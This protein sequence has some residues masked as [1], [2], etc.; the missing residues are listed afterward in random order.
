MFRRPV[1]LL[2]A[3]V[4]A[5]HVDAGAVAGQIPQSEYAARRARV[6]TVME[7]RGVLLALGAR[8]PEFDYVS[9]YQG[10]PFNYLTGF[11]EPGAALVMVKRG[12]AATATLFVLPRDPAAEV[13]TGSRLGVTGAR[14]ATALAVRPA[15]DLRTVLDSLLDGE[16]LL[17][18][19][20]DFSDT[21]GGPLSVDDQLLAAVV[22][23]NPGTRTTDVTTDAVAELRG[24]KSPAE[25]ALL[26]KAIEITVAAQRE[27]MRLM[28]PGMNEFEVEAL[29][30]YTFRRNGAERPGFASIVG[31]GPNSTTLHYNANDRFMQDG[32]LV[33]MDVGASYRGYTADVTRT[34]PVSG[35]F[36]ADQRAIYQIVRD[37]QA[38]AERQV[39][40]GAPA[41]GMTDSA[42]TVIAAG[43]AQLGLIDS[44]SAMYD[45][46]DPASPSRCPQF[47][48]YFMHGLGHGIG[49][50]VH[51]PDQFYFTGH[52]GVGSAFT[53]EPGIY[54]RENLAEELLDTPRNRAML[55][56]IGAEIERYAN[57]GVRIEDDYFVT[58]SGVEW[59]SR[60]PREIEEIEAIMRARY[61]GPARRSD[62]MVGWYR[63]AP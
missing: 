20:G 13:W 15:A 50:D 3:A 54:V 29:I 62:E 32:E 21:D 25:L 23:A 18:V 19:V 12:D 58:E 59:V 60:A 53:I 41:A 22:R 52:I 30:E 1:L 43:L 55:A 33:V 36:T 7:E 35:T 28:E 2:F 37:A 11:R 5:L 44:A 40:P 49:L 56:N 42:S 14:A 26:R 48:M 61:S 4:L 57:I 47:R 16:R 45:C 8:E 9:F 38:A 46:G 6:A 34:V 39:R 10:S 27:A 31:S 51:D 63:A 17:Y 24:T